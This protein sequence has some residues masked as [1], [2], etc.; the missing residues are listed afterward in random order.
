MYKIINLI[1]PESAKEL[2]KRILSSPSLSDGAATAGAHGKMKKKNQQLLPSTDDGKIILSATR[3][4]I[5]ENITVQQTV[6]PKYLSSI[7]ANIYETGDHYKAHVDVP[8]MGNQEAGWFR[9][10][11]SFTLFLSDPESYEGGVLNLLSDGGKISAKLK[12]GQLVVY[13]SG[14]LHE[15]EEVTAGRRVAIVGWMQSFL[16]DDQIRSACTGLEK[17]IF[18]LR[19][20][21]DH[22]NSE[23]A[24]V[25]LHSFLRTG[26]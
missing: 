22:K 7:M 25:I 26:S 9:A 14:L 12:P 21:G 1:S 3:K 19:A 17:L 13:R 8:W 5:L 18:S 6:F 23:D 11:F 24:K 20:L 10:D 2:E 16:K 4:A 15:V